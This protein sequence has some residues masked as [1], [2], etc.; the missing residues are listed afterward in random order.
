MRK[1]SLLL[2]LL[3][4]LGLGACDDILEEDI[5]DARVVL[6][7][8][9]DDARLQQNKVNFLWE[10]V[11]GATAYHVQLVQPSFNEIEALVVDTFVV[12]PYFSYTLPAGEY[13][14]G[15][16]AV[17]SVYGTAYTIRSFFVEGTETPG[18][19]GIN[20]LYPQNELVTK[21]STISFAWNKVA[22]VAAYS[23]QISG[24][25]NSK[26]QLE[27][28]TF[29]FTLP[30]SAFNKSLNWQVFGLGEDLQPKYYSPKRALL[31]DTN[32]PASAKLLTPAVDAKFRRS[33]PI[34]FSWEKNNDPDFL[35][36]RLIVSDK[37]TNNLIRTVEITNVAE[38]SKALF[39]ID[40]GIPV[41]E[42]L[43]QIETVD[44]LGNTST[45]G[46]ERRGFEII[47]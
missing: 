6:R 1:S 25:W 44:K 9:A 10:P 8:P 34:T 41:A 32:P 21:D 4:I 3:G 18:E 43:W 45:L 42:Y 40:D 27:D 26:F 22:G 17:N 12:E 23:L 31:I 29:R 19:P 24:G 39:G 47:E 11:S 35:K 16:S 13:Q 37:A 2:L 20:L 28:T 33:E 15:V 5:S 46:V 38:T 36:Y 30:R 7:A 14:W